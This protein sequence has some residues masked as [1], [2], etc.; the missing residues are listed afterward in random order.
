M[1]NGLART[2]AK[3]RSLELENDLRNFLFDPDSPTILD[4]FSLNI[5]RGR[6]HGICSL[7]DARQVVGLPK[8]TDFK[9]I[10]ENQ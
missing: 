6:D 8:K 10:F 3:Q 5:A 9:Q 7:N 1:I 2:G 4:L